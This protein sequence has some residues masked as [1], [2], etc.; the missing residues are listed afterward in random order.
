MDRGG[1][2]APITKAL[3]ASI[4]VILVVTVVADEMRAA[5][6]EASDRRVARPQGRP[7]QPI[8]GPLAPR[9]YPSC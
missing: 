6:L 2:C 9:Y 5:V 1:R 7:E 4:D 3:D 8:A